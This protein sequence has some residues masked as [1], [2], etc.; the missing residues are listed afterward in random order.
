MGRATVPAGLGAA[1]LGEPSRERVECRCGEGHAAVP[2]FDAIG[3]LV[4]RCPVRRPKRAGRTVHPEHTLVPVRLM[5]QS[6]ALAMQLPPVAPGQLRCQLCAH[7]VDGKARLCRTCR[8][9]QR[10][11]RRRRW[12]QRTK[13]P[14][15]VCLCACGRTHETRNGRTTCRTCLHCTPVGTVRARAYKPKPC[16]RCHRPFTPTG[17]RAK[18]HPGG[19]P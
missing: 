11:S 6:E 1:A 9:S 10:N 19:C 16:E 2:E 5:R 17:P 15:T 12:I 13:K 8:R 4:F 3:N 14:L 7:G 18:W